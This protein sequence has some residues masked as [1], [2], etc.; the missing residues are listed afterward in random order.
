MPIKP[1]NRNRYPANWKQIRA[2]I[3]DRA[4]H[5]CEQ[6]NAPNRTLIA[7]GVGSDDGTY[8]LADGGDVFNSETGER[9]GL[10]RGGEYETKGL[11]EVVLTIA[12]LDHVPENCEPANLKALCQRCH[13]RYD[14]EHHKAN[15]ASTRRARRAMGDLFDRAIEAAKGAK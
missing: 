14:F 8:M 5:K 12:H 6:C 9:L 4:G 1:E 3:L 13:L 15:A 2:S 10:A 7:R 11:I